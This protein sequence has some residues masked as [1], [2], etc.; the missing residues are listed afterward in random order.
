MRSKCIV[1]WFALLPMWAGAQSPVLEGY[2]QEGLK[3]NLQLQQEQ[4]SYEKSVDNLGLARAL[5]MPQVSAIANYTLAGGGRKI[6]FP[7]GDL[8]NPVYTTLNQLTNSSAFPQIANVN[9]QFLPNHFHETKFRVVQPLFNPD[10]YFNYKAQK[11]LITVQQAQ[12]NAFQNELKFN[13]TSAYYQYLQSEEALV[14]LGKTKNLLQ[15]LLKVNTSL[16]ANAKATKDVVL[17]TEYELS[18]LEQQIAENEKNNQVARAYFNFL[19]NRD[20]ETSIAKDTAV[21]ST[22]T[23]NVNLEQ[24]TQEAISNRQEVKQ[25]EGGLRANEQLVGLQKGNALWPKVNVVGDIGYQGFQYKFDQ[26][27]QFYLVQFGLSW[28]L[29]KG[30]EKK[31]RVQQ[32]RIDQSV[33]ENKM[34]QLKKQIEL[35]V[36]QSHY[37]LET[38]RQAYAASQSGVRSTERSFQIIRSKYNEG[39]AILLE[40]LDAQNKLTTARLTQ[41]INHYELLRKEAA[42]HKTLSNL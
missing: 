19:L 1:I 33:L 17:N 13:I 8:L 14:I 7:V 40:Y 2:I 38:A 42:L 41:S 3:S 26:P 35:Q 31:T 21:M 32:A 28:D 11:E 10:I 22:S 34:Q 27:Q 36:I 25:L 5:F 30:R 16:V 12:K 39:Q 15:E 29:F 4:L 18:K 20:L 9:E 24:L 37:E 23:N 6:Q